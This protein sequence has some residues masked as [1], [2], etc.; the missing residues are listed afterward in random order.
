MKSVKTLEKTT[1]SGRRFTRKQLAQVQETVQTFQHLSRK[2][3]AQTIC[4]HLSWKTPKGTNKTQ[5]GLVLLEELEARGII[6]LPAKR[7]TR[8]PVR[9]QIPL[10]KAEAPISD[11]LAAIGPI[12]LQLATTDEERA[13][14]KSHVQTYHYLGYKRPVGSHL[15][16]FVVSEARQ[17]KLG[18]LLFSASAAWALAPRD[19]WIG[20]AKKH[21][22]KLLNLILVQNRFL[23]FPW[24]KVPNLATKILSLTAKQ[25]GD[26]WVRI[27]GYRPVLIET[28]VDTTKYSGAS[29][30]A[31]N[32]RYL[33]ET[34]GRGHD[35]KHEQKKSRK[36]IYAYPLQSDWQ[37]CLTGGH[38]M[39]AL[40]KRY[41]NDLQS[42]HSRSV[43]DAFVTLWEKVVHILHEVAQ[44]YDDKWRIRKRV[45]DSLILMLLIF[46]L[47]SSKNAQSYG[48]TIDELWDSCDQLG[49]SLPQKNSIAPSSFCAARKKLDEAIFKCVN[50]NILATYAP[51]ASHFT[52]L[53]HR[54][55]AVDGSKLN[56][57][58]KLV[59]CG[60]KTP[61]DNAH[62]PQGLLS[63]L[64]QLK[65]QLPF[66]FDLVSHANERVCA[67]QHLD[68]L[69]KNDVVVYDRGYFSYVML[70]Q[71]YQTGIH[72]IFRLEE[73]SYNVIREFFTSPNT[74]MLV[75]ISPS[76]KTLSDIQMK[77][78][79]LDIIPLKMRL[80]K[81]EKGGS[82]LATPAMR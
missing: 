53:G 65:S 56:L 71:H 62:Y 60:Y 48:T 5:S 47:V 8:A 49:L 74:D 6:N 36:A 18:C 77:H 78:P 26:D 61:S 81:Y 69:E 7:Q 9:H 80:I 54:L 76:K 22:Q 51:E 38:Q 43:G 75:T 72:A 12:S 59:A 57:P 17:Q 11:S 55:F 14:W 46:R 40:K 16:Y 31:A 24:V 58:R 41:R 44:E 52:W 73:N 79:E 13:C 23:I 21:K 39:K 42:S 68:V 66:D 2:E 63:C 10:K 70:H 25:V 29:Y 35:P 45:L 15:Y 34:Q 20:W 30:R 3:L 37:Q 27:H 32:W 1:F 4:E 19:Q 50:R 67:Q 64:Y 28:F 33:G 82:R